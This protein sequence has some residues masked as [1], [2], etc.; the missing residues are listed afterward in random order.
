MKQKSII[1]AVIILAVIAVG[2]YFAFFN[3]S[4]ASTPSINNSVTQNTPSIQPAQ[5]SSSSQASTSATSLIQG[6]TYGFI[7]TQ[8]GNLP[9]KVDGSLT[10]KDGT[11]TVGVRAQNFP[12]PTSGKFYEAW[13]MY[14]N[15]AKPLAAMAHSTDPTMKKDFV[16]GYQVQE[17]LQNYDTV[18]VSLQSASNNATIETPLFKGPIKQNP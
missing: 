4:P 7:L 14:G 6:Q 12:E 16:L 3:Q 9:G 1:I 8:V 18:V 11:L 17:T 15:T 2:V 10:Y 13:I 5:T